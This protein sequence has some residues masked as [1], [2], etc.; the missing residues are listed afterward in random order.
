LKLLLT[1]EPLMKAQIDVADL[2]WNSY[3]P[4]QD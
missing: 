3:F 2:L 1:I 4:K